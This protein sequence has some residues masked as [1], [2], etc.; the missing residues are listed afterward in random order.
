MGDQ[1]FTDRVKAAFDGLAAIVGFDPEGEQPRMMFG[2][3]RDAKKSMLQAHNFIQQAQPGLAAMS[4]TDASMAYM[5]VIVQQKV[6]W[7]LE[8]PGAVGSVAASTKLAKDLF[9]EWQ[10]GHVLAL[11]N[12]LAQSEPFSKFTPDQIAAEIPQALMDASHSKAGLLKAS[13]IREGH[14]PMPSLHGRV[15]KLSPKIPAASTVS[16]II[17]HLSLDPKDESIGVALA[18]KV[19]QRIDLSYFVV[20]VSC[21]GWIWVLSD[22][23]E[24]ENPRNKATTRNPHRRRENAYE[25]LGFPYGIIDD[26]C[27][28]NLVAKPG[29]PFLHFFDMENVG[30]Y[31]MLYT[32]FTIEEYLPEFTP[33]LDKILSFGEAM[34]LLIGDGMQIDPLDEAGFEYMGPEAKAVITDL[35]EHLPGKAKS[36]DLVLVG[37]Q[38]IIKHEQYDP[39]WMGTQERHAAMAKWYAVDSHA[40]KVGE[41][42]DK[43]EK[44]QEADTKRLIEMLRAPGNAERVA[45]LLAKSPLGYSVQRVQTGTFSTEMESKYFKFS[46]WT[47]NNDYGPTWLPGVGFWG[48]G[49]VLAFENNGRK[50]ALCGKEHGRLLTKNM[51][52]N[53]HTSEHLAWVLN[54]K[55]EELPLYWRAYRSHHSIPYMGNSILDNTHP[56]LNLEHPTWHAHPNGLRATMQFC[57]GCENKLKKQIEFKRAVISDG[58]QSTEMPDHIDPSTETIRINEWDH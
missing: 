58:L 14:G 6:D 46:Q 54:C 39:D 36:T 25:N 49:E 10:T 23:I 7:H 43:L 41:R 3:E 52:I 16:S 24:F 1:Q 12:S 56:F 4:L 18:M 57:S 32:V 44:I 8:N 51:A 15:F 35:L 27:K 30:V 21:K 19:E 37:Q 13:L 5:E 31:H 34:P 26:L 28:L 42:I 33:A 40:R 38:A 47:V 20:V 11:A 9:A 2:S 17:P 50:C 29:Q 55:R 45:N 53:V 48:H 22:A